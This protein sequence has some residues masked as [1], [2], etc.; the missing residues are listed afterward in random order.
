MV[1]ESLKLINIAVVLYFL[2]YY[3]LFLH[4][5]MAGKWS[6]G[7]GGGA[8]APPLDPPLRAY[9]YTYHTVI[10]SVV[11]TSSEIEAF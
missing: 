3:L 5:W 11:L 6:G 4:V 8:C 10:L 7:G 2:V 1:T 9:T